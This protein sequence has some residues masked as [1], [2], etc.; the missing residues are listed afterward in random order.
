MFPDVT[1]G[2]LA[3]PL[4]ALGLVGNVACSSDETLTP[5]P[6][7]IPPATN[8]NTGNNNAG[9]NNTGNNNTENPPVVELAKS[10]KANVRFKRNLRIR[11]DFAQAMGLEP[12]EVCTEL[13]QYSCT[14]VVHTISLGGVEPYVLG[15]NEPGDDTTATTPIAAE[16]V[17]LFACSERVRRDLGGDAQIFRDLPIADGRLLDPDAEAVATAIDTLYKRAL[18]RAA[19]PAEIAH[20]RQLYLDISA[21]GE[22][23][24][25]RD[26][27][28]LSCFSVLTSMESL[29]Y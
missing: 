16:R 14:D 12:G 28:V 15:L 20:H 7:G 21:D 2:R 24:A 17:A 26:W 22:A 25:A 23:D 6:P 13:G 4:L 9:N 10:A 11:N 3:A 27:A 19:T 1:F 29:F 18:L 5:P 8:N